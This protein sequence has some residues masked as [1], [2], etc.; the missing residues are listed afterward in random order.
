[1]ALH[2]QAI[3]AA[4]V[5]AKAWPQPM[6]TMDPAVARAHFE[7]I[8]T[9]AGPPVE[10]VRDVTI[11][12]KDGPIPLRVYT[13]HGPGP[14]GALVYFH[15]GGWVVGSIANADGTV[16]QIVNRAKCV[17]VSVG[18]RLAPEHKCPTAVDDCYSAMA[19]TALHAGA[20]KVRPDALAVGGASSGGN[21]AAAVALMSR[22]KGGPRL[23]HQSLIY[24]VIERRFTTRSYI[25]NAQGPFLTRS[26]ME[27]YWSLYLR[28]AKDA[29]DPY[30]SPIHAPSLRDLP[31]A[32]VA[33]AEHDPL[34]DEGRAYAQ[35]LQEAGVPVTYKDY[36]GMIHGFFNMWKSID[37]GTEAIEDLCDALQRA[38]GVA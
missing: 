35:A 32:F 13:P 38:F 28:D 23:V 37:S 29:L 30:A 8:P 17:V 34:R 26:M 25:E 15:G 9:S 19:W 7:A 27:W 6:E 33:T 14:F 4:Q 1:M 20:L 16:R 36:P 3:A 22:D 10:S 31:P 2:P 11:V 21:L 18:D 5:F 12:S 24:P